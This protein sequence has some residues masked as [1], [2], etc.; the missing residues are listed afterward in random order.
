V[1]GSGLR[2]SGEIL[3]KQQ[4]EE[5]EFIKSQFNSKRKVFDFSHLDSLTL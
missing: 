1:S 2:Q 4:I 3:T 5:V